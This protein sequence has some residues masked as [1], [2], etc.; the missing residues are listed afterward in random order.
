VCYRSA[1]VRAILSWETVAWSHTSKCNCNLL[2]CLDHHVRNNIACMFADRGAC[3]LAAS[4]TNRWRP[5]CWCQR[6][7]VEYQYKA[8]VMLNGLP[9]ISVHQSMSVLK[10][11][12]T[13]VLVVYSKPLSWRS[14]SS[15]WHC[16]LPPPSNC[17]LSRKA[18][19]VP[20]LLMS[21]AG[22]SFNNY[23]IRADQAMTQYCI[24][25]LRT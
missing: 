22:L 23:H 8:M 15:P 4:K 13:F 3:V 12:L 14:L 9:V 11:L 24:C 18:N 16:P 7:S 19:A 21:K 17:D 25:W 20:F 5:C 1:A 2:C 10:K 6:T